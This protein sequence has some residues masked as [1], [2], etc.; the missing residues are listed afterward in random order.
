MLQIIL[1]SF[2]IAVLISLLVMLLA[3]SIVSCHIKRIERQLAQV[4]DI[5]RA[6][7]EGASYEQL[8]DMP[9]PKKLRKQLVKRLGN[10]RYRS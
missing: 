4:E 10:P 7:S 5:R 6:L 2:V 9:M 3:E 8:W 1:L